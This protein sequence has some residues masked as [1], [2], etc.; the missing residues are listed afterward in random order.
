MIF[1]FAGIL[2]ALPR[3]RDGQLT[4]SGIQT[5]PSFDLSLVLRSL[6]LSRNAILRVVSAAK[7]GFVRTTAEIKAHSWVLVMPPATK[8]HG[9]ACRVS[10]CATPSVNRPEGFSLILPCA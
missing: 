7:H 2:Y 9:A 1:L 4:A 10:P 5:L 6:S 3:V 8:K